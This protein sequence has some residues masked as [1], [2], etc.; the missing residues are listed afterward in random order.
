MNE[1][2]RIVEKII[3]EYKGDETDIVI[4]FGVEEIGMMAFSYSEQLLSV[5]IPQTVK[6]IGHSAFAYC[7]NLEKVTIPDEV[8]DISGCAFIGCRNLTKLRLPAKYRTPYC[9][10]NKIKHYSSEELEEMLNNLLQKY[11]NEDLPYT[12]EEIKED[13]KEYPISEINSFV[14]RKYGTK[15]RKYLLVHNEVFPGAVSENTLLDSTVDYETDNASNNNTSVVKAPAMTKED[16]DEIITILQNRYKEKKASSVVQIAGENK[17]LNIS[18]INRFA[19]LYYG[20]TRTDLLIEK[21]ILSNSEPVNVKSRLVYNSET[22]HYEEEDTYY[23]TV[24]EKL[25]EKYKDEKAEKLLQVYGEN[26]NISAG[27]FN[28]RKKKKYGLTAKE[29]LLQKGVIEESAKNGKGL[30]DNQVLELG[31]SYIEQLR[32]RYLDH[33]AQSLM[34]VFEENPEISQGYFYKYARLKGKRGVKKLLERE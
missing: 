4:P 31:E 32:E 18:A 14:V 22:K 27:S 2:Y 16:L 30:S 13:N 12:I 9:E 20:M 6:K 33:K 29:F 5:Q 11:S 3:L 17:D 23:E 19:N 26:N 24:I 34:Q 25:I 15:L 28:K 10:N 21:G 7:D 1:D 8:E